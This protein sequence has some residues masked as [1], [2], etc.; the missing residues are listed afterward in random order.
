MGQ[1]NYRE[2]MVFY[3]LREHVDR[4]AINK[5]IKDFKEED[6]IETG[7]FLKE[8]ALVPIF[9]DRLIELK[10]E[11]IPAE[12]LLRLKNL[13]LLN[14]Q[15]NTMLERELFKVT[16]HLG[17]GNIPVIPLK[18][19]ILCRLLYNDIALRGTSYDLDLLIPYERLREAEEKLQEKGY[20]FADRPELIEYHHKFNKEIVFY[21][22]SGNSEIN[23]DLHWYIVDER[24]NDTCIRDFWM[25]AKEINLDGHKILIPSIEDLLF[26]LSLHAV[27]YGHFVVIKYLYDIHRIVK[28]YGKE[29]NWSDLM[30]KA[31]ENNLAK[32]LFYSLSL[33]RDF[34]ETPVSEEVLD[35]IRPHRIKEL[36]LMQWINKYNVLKRRQNIISSWIWISF[37][38]PLLYTNTFF[39]YLELVVNRRFSPMDIYV[40]LCSKGAEISLSNSFRKL[41][42]N[43]LKCFFTISCNERKVPVS[44]M[45]YI[46]QNHSERNLSSK[47][48]E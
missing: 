40:E 17:T 35:A 26:Y 33:S 29:I 8:N 31:R 9:Y 21:K 5:I 38:S 24:L 22:K 42:L 36:I 10:L 12:F 30:R 14:L 41:S 37:V 1:L 4:D 48:N 23:L 19:I 16:D 6:W 2:D 47:S 11:H 25:N 27:N 28:V 44:S 7:D 43:I 15:R 32:S 3:L 34:F 39:D 46:S 45:A 18:G 13:Y 20:S